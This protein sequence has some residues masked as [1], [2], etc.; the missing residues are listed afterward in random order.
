MSQKDYRKFFD[1][2]HLN[3]DLKKQSLRSG[4]VTL[5]SQGLM[6]FIQ[7]GSTMILA[8]ILTPRDYGVMAMVVSITG[9]AAILSNLGL[10][11]A[12]VQRAEISHE[13]VSALFWIN[14]GVG[15]GVALV[16]A[17]LSPVVAWFYQTPELFWVMLALSS[18]FFI[19]GLAIQ[20][21]ALLS[22]QMRFYSAAKIQ[23]ISTLIGIGV[24]IVAAQHGFGYW[25][26]VLNSIITSVTSV[27]GT[28]FASGW[29]PSLPRRNTDVKSMVKFGYDV[30]GF[31]V[32]NYFSR[33]LDNVLIGRYY[34]SVALGLYS[35]A[36]QLLMMPITN[37]RD[38]LNRVAMPSLSRLQNE[39]EQYRNF[40]IKFISILAFVS[41]PG[42]VFMYV[43][44]D[45][46]ISLVLGSQWMGASE[47][48]KILAFAGLIQVT[49]STRGVVL[50][51]TGK[52]RKYLWWGAGNAFIT[53][54]SFVIGL[55]WGPKGVATSY[56][57]ANYLLLYPSLLYVF[58]DTPVC[59]GDFFTA[60]YKP[61][62]ASLA[63]GSAC[64]LLLRN[65]NSWP[66][67]A[68][69]SV[70]FVVSLGA[71]LLALI[72]LSGGSKDIREYY[73]YGRLVFAKK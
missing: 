70:C 53:I 23:A 6:F 21:S 65:L 4:A 13:Q 38:P 46:L 69:L 44:S 73:S 41:M 5:I 14:A 61:L 59:V 47:I 22:R 36:Y 42:V 31:N 54:L 1:T 37:L 28:W 45:N 58:K 33:N 12:T 18:N 55:P 15:T 66:D 3:L 40:Y 56:A 39:P 48:F 35:K 9:L 63:M 60:I 2:K 67:V 20:H 32:I 24:A 49:G 52:S 57:V 17:M 11:T 16:G 43:C 62:V 19:N 27:V 26:L 71:Y 68:A 50:L 34:G 25:A 72:V 64:F 8:R 10:S 30:V 51:S 7:L 29:I